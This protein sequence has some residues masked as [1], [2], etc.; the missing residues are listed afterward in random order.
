METKRNLSN[1]NFRLNRAAIERSPAALRRSGVSIGPPH[2][3][4][5][6]DLRDDAFYFESC[7]SGARSTAPSGQE[8]RQAKTVPKLLGC[9]KTRPESNAAEKVQ[10]TQA[11]GVAIFT[12][13]VVGLRLEVRLQELDEIPARPTAAA[14]DNAG[15]VLKVLR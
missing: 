4:L 9:A 10:G 13:Q 5:I 11:E 1:A 7:S 14:D 15:G 2:G 12:E 3:P 6:I 8:R